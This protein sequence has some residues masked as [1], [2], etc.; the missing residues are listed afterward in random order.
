MQE[1]ENAQLERDRANKERAE[2][3][4]QDEMARK[5]PNVEV[6]AVDVQSDNQ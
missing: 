2:K 4:R 6:Q 1:A 5:T 3:E